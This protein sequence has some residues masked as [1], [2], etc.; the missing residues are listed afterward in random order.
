MRW[1]YYTEVLGTSLKSA[2]LKHRSLFPSDAH[3]GWHM[4]MDG[5][6]TSVRLALANNIPTMNFYL[7]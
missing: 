7:R 1:L 4:N 3:Y 5:I 2:S 6:W